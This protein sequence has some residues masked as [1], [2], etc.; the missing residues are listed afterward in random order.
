MR[1]N[2]LLRTEFAQ[3]LSVHPVP[4]EDGDSVKG[5]RNAWWKQAS[6]AFPSEMKMNSAPK[7]SL[8]SLGSAVGDGTEPSV[9]S[10]WVGSLCVPSC[11]TKIKLQLV[12]VNRQGSHG[13]DSNHTSFVHLLLPGWSWPILPVCLEQSHRD[14]FHGIAEFQSGL[15]WGGP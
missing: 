11:S 13:T 5:S 7:G 9:H 15:G 12:P 10:S 4:L 6:L 3:A 8:G 1:G 2:V 14:L